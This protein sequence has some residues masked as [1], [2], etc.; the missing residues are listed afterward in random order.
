MRRD[1][2][3]TA[4]VASLAGLVLA[5]RRLAK[6]PTRLAQHWASRTRSASW[7]DA[8][9]GAGMNHAVRTQQVFATIVWER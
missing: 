8:I 6:R 4:V 3:A 5:K 7:H 1:C 2:A 9:R